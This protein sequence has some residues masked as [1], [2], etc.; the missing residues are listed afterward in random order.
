MYP[1]SFC[2]KFS[3]KIS[4]KIC[5][6]L[7]CMRFL[8][9]WS[10]ETQKNR[11]FAYTYD[12]TYVATKLAM[13]VVL[14]RSQIATLPVV[15]SYKTQKSYHST[16]CACTLRIWPPCVMLGYC[17]KCYQIHAYIVGGN[18]HCVIFAKLC[19]SQQISLN[20]QCEPH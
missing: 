5:S 3:H 20:F 11:W 2:T 18:V 10:L 13:S 9:T 15:A 7:S 19:Q 14:V 1:C 12:C 16:P 17:Q 6:K 4:H 8:Q